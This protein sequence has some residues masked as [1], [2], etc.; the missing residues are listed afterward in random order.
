MT[1]LLLHEAVL[2]YQALIIMPVHSV[3][4]YFKILSRSEDMLQ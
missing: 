3:K 2:L 1:K 4:D